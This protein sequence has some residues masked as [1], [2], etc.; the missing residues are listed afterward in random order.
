ML[1][2]AKFRELGS[3]RQDFLRLRSADIKMRVVY[4]DVL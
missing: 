4:M 3:G 2:F 1:V